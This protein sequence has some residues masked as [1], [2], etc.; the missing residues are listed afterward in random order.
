[1]DLQLQDRH[2]L[3]TGGSKGIGLACALGF[4]REG[5]RVSLVSRDLKNLEQGRKTLVEAFAEAEGRVSVHAADLKDPAGAVA[6]LDAAEQAFGPVDVLV[7][8]AGAARRTPPDELN[9]AAWHDAMDAKY[10]TYIHMIDPVV[11]R[12]GQRGQGAIVN[13]IGQGGK[14]ASPV[15][16]AGGAANAALMLVSAGMASAYAAKGVRVNAVNPGLTLTE[17]LQEGLK[18]DAK[19]QG[20]GSDEALQRAKA[21][22][23]LGRIAAPEEIANAV[24]FLA[25]PRA[26]YI[27][28][29]IVAMDGA[30][31]P[32]I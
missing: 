24:V 31:T 11:K 5:A 32:M 26:S 13:V 19:L 10:F 23:P 17:R 27:T 2:V 4:L 20:I 8:S 29:A 6:A 14:V 12:M 3:I 9:A 1:M 16:M 7:N 30:V 28:G 15:H 21:R 25:S 22:L 18:A